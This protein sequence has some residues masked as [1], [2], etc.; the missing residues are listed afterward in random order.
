MWRG[1]KRTLTLRI[2]DY[3]DALRGHEND[4]ICKEILELEESENLKIRM[5]NAEERTWR[6]Y[7]N[8]KKAEVDPEKFL[9]E[10]FDLPRRLVPLPLVTKKPWVSVVVKSYRS[11]GAAALDLGLFSG[12]TE[13]STRWQ[14]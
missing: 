4:P 3:Q 11:L 13:A 1:I 2:K 14:L 9:C 5:K 7:N 10:Y 8:D 12:W 6:S